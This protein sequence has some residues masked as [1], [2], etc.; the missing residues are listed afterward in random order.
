MSIFDSGAESLEA[1]WSRINTSAEENGIAI[2]A[3]IYDYV[4][5]V[6]VAEMLILE[7]A[8]RDLTP[9]ALAVRI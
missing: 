3:A 5:P 1:A 2:G 8:E 7:C 9:R 4:H 6:A